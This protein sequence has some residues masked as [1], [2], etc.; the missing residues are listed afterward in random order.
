V[1]GRITPR[2]RDVAPGE[3]WSENL[4]KAVV[5]WALAEAGG[6]V[7]IILGWIIG[8]AT[9]LALGAA[10]SLA[11]LVTSRPARLES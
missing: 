2:R 7:G 11:L 4:P 3:W 5:V 8:D 9:L 1:R 10:V 6:L